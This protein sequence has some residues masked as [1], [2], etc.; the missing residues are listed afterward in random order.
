MSFS[1][2]IY[3]ETNLLAK[4][5]NFSITSKA[6][7]NKDT[8]ATI[9]DAVKNLENEEADTICAKISLTLQNSKLPRDYLS[10]YECKAFKK[11]QPDA[12]IVILLT[13]KGR[14]IVLFKREDYLEKCMDHMKNGPYQLLKKDNT[15]KIKDKTLKQL[16]A[17]D[18]NRFTDNKLFY[19]LQLTDLPFVYI[20]WSVLHDLLFNLVVPCCAIV[21]NTELHF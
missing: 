4:G 1:Q 16:K 7:P 20:L 14:S 18:D 5:L 21:T 8:I 12:L 19:Y 9:K 13:G 6:L 2:L 11:L 15:T 10:K 17:L 3:I